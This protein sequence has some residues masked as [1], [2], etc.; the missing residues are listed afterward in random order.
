MKIKRD[1]VLGLATI[2]L[3]IVTVGCATGGYHSTTPQEHAMWRAAETGNVE[4]QRRVAV[5]LS[6]NSPPGGAETDAGYAAFWFREACDQQYA[7]AAVSFL[8]LAEYEER[9]S[10]DSSHVSHALACLHSAIEQGH[11]EAIRA[12]AIRA[13]KREKNFG[14][15]YYLYALMQEVD[16]E[17]ADHRWEIVE[18]LI[19]GE[20]ERME[21]RARDWLASNQ[22]K[23]DDDFLRELSSDRG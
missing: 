6:P 9:R 15:A 17:F 12:G 18:H 22:L 19:Q 20:R 1:L 3:A 4:A 14:R 16:P 7:N 23:G 2:S 10:R 11:R 21:R 5:D 8:E 13:T